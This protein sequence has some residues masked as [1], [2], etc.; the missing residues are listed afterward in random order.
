MSKSELFIDFSDYKTGLYDFEYEGFNARMRRRRSRVLD[1]EDTNTEQEVIF[2]EAFDSFSITLNPEDIVV[3]KECL[4]ETFSVARNLS[5]P[6]VEIDTTKE[7]GRR[8]ENRVQTLFDSIIN[9]GDFQ[10]TEQFSIALQNS[11]LVRVAYMYL[12]ENRTYYM[13]RLNNSV[14]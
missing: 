9:D 2:M 4:R 14:M 13:L 5:I 3:R 1:T 12:N 10:E 6:I 11:Q 7:T 8:G